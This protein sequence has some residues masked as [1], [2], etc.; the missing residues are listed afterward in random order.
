MNAQD[1][2]DIGRLI[3]WGLR[4]TA[5]PAQDQEYAALID[6]YMDEPEFRQATLQ[7]A[8]GLGLDII[9][10]GPTGL[11]LVPLDDSVFAMTP[12]D[13]RRRPL[14]AELR[15]VDGLI[16]VG[17]AATV[18]PR[19]EDMDEDPMLARPPISPARVDET[20][21][22]VVARMVEAAKNAPDPARSDL[23][24]GLIEAWRLYEKR[25]AEKEGGRTRWHSSTVQQIRTALDRMVD[26]GLFARVRTS[27]DT[28]QATYAYQMRIRNQAVREVM[29]CL[30]DMQPATNEEV[31]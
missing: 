27:A 14:D 19:P 5:R 26:A 28:Y 18:F 12:A 3:Q 25:P 30:E 23:E 6:R 15:L 2:S 1:L 21:R 29:R 31:R 13:F 8:T 7:V 22:T 20:V 24:Q 9:D 16:Q 4:P 10:S 11:L 17:I